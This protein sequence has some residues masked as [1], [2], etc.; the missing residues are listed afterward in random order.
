MLFTAGS[1]S[2]TID[3]NHYDVKPGSVFIMAPGQVH[4][5]NLSKDVDGFV[6]FHTRQ[7]LD[8][9]TVLAKAETSSLFSFAQYPSAVKLSKHA[10]KSIQ[11]HIQLI[12]SEHE[13]D[14][15]GK[16][17]YMRLLI[18]QVYLE[19]A[20]TFIGTGTNPEKQSPYYFKYLEFENLLETNFRVLKSASA[21]ADLLHISA[22][23]LNRIVQSVIGKSTSEVI[24]ER[25]ILEAKR[26]LIHSDKNFA[27]IAD[28]LGF[29]DYSYFSHVFK[30]KTG[31]S[32]SGFVKEAAG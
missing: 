18:Q 10:T 2:H 21:Y 23:H 29:D 30:K 9:N 12:G 24:L 31:K 22:K 32:P 25:I 14:E 26:M 8:R 16:K 15:F 6:L 1:G 5:W 7:F 20:R 3:F 27:E 19:L 13:G 11:A 4:S 28:D 17:E